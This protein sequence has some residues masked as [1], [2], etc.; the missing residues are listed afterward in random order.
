MMEYLVLSDGANPTLSESISPHSA[1]VP[2]CS[3]EDEYDDRIRLY[4]LYVCRFHHYPIHS[5]FPGSAATNTY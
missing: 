1:Y 5:M 3:P 4:S 2:R